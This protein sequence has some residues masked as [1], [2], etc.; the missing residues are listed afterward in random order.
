V[1][2]GNDGAKKNDAKKALAA[3]KHS[4]VEEVRVLNN[5]GWEMDKEL[6]AQS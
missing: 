5:K 4:D 2:N 3:V 1:A 6:P